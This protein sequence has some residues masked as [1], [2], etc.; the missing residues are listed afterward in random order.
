MAK[1]KTY[2]VGRQ[3]RREKSRKNEGRK[4]KKQRVLSRGEKTRG[5]VHFRGN[6]RIEGAQCA[7]TRGE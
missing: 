7:G 6:Q 1:G 5:D 4:M 2:E 3:K